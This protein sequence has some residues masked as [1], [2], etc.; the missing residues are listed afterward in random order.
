MRLIKLVT[1]ETPEDELLLPRFS[2]W[3]RMTRVGGIRRPPLR[4]DRKR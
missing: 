4:R 3:H 1:G 2:E